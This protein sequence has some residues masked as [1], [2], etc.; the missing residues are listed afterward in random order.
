MPSSKTLF[1]GWLLKNDPNHSHQ[2][3][4]QV[5]Q[6]VAQIAQKYFGSPTLT[7]Q[8]SATPTIHGVVN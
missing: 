4:A 8:A 5:Q 1:V 3:I 7:E 6:V 2:R